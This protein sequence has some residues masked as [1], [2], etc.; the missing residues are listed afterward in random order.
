MIATSWVLVSFFG[1]MICGIP[2]GMAWK[3]FSQKKIL[4]ACFAWMIMAVWIISFAVS[5]VADEYSTPIEIHGLLGAVVGWLFGQEFVRVR[6][7]KENG[8]NGEKR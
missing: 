6:A 4:Q 8:S 3:N 5:V 1:G 2:I 7:K